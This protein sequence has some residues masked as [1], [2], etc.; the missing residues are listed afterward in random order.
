M[1]GL[2]HMKRSRIIA[3][4]SGLAIVGLGIFAVVQLNSARSTLSIVAV[5]LSLVPMYF[6][7]SAVVLG[8]Y[9]KKEKQ[10]KRDYAMEKNLKDKRSRSMKK[11]AKDYGKVLDFPTDKQK[12]NNKNN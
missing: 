12:K 3:L 5:V 9:D 1:E 11:T 10:P 7:Y 8:K 4:V 6:L 2:I